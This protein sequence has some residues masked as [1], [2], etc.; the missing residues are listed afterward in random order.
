MIVAAEEGSPK[1]MEE[2][3]HHEAAHAAGWIAAGLRLHF[4]NVIPACDERSPT[5]TRLGIASSGDFFDARRYALATRRDRSRPG[6]LDPR[7]INAMVGELAGDEAAERLCAERGWEAGMARAHW[8]RVAAD[9]IAVYQDPLR[10]MDPFHSVVGRARRFVSDQWPAITA[11][12]AELIVHKEL[13]GGVATD[14]L[15]LHWT[16]Q[17][18]SVGLR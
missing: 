1:L 5:G 12:A 2:V 14:I 10:A 16:G 13:R 3:A 6:S 4:V 18:P 9:V 8:G 7:I 15:L 11:L 17:R